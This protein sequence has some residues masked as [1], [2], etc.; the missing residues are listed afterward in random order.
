MKVESDI[1]QSSQMTIQGDIF[2]LRRD[3]PFDRF[4]TLAADG[5]AAVAGENATYTFT[6]QPDTHRVEGGNLLAKYSKA[7]D[8][9]SK[10]E[11]QAYYDVTDRLIDIL[12]YNIKTID[13]E[14]CPGLAKERLQPE[15]T[16]GVD[17]VKVLH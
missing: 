4:P 7:F 3:E 8:D 16:R 14:V 1:D 15:L 17:L 13:L 2:K 6:S 11:L 12:D 5:G 9:E 10:L